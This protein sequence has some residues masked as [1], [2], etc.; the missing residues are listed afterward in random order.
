MCV[1]ENINSFGKNEFERFY[2]KKPNIKIQINM[3]FFF[4]KKKNPEEEKRIFFGKSSVSITWKLPGNLI[5]ICL[6]RQNLCNF[7]T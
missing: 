7:S 5:Q 2:S 1:H 4:P 3:K 6:L